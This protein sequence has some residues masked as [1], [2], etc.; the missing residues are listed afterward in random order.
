M[1]NFP[2]LQH[3]RQLQWAL[4]H[5][6]A[7]WLL[8]LAPDILD[9][10]SHALALHERNIKELEVLGVPL[11]SLSDKIGP[12]RK[13]DKKS[14]WRLKH[15]VNPAEFIDNFYTVIDAINEVRRD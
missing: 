6:Y 13:G 8:V 14:E 10:L 2:A 3:L 4:K 1:I 9:R 11:T 7:D 15:G 5:G 12:V